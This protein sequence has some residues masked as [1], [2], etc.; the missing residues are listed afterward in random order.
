[1][2]GKGFDPRSTKRHALKR[3]VLKEI[4]GWPPLGTDFLVITRKTTSPWKKKD[5]LEDLS[6][7]KSRLL[8]RNH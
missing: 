4:T 3:L 8:G 1:V 5:I 6:I 2:V 7:I